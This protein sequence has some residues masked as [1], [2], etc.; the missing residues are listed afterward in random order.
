MKRQ[1]VKNAA[2]KTTKKKHSH[3][4]YSSK[5]NKSGGNKDANAS[6]SYGLRTSELSPMPKP[7]RLLDEFIIND[8]GR[9]AEA[10]VK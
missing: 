8:F 1:S 5:A 4:Y 2:T 10:K 3:Y 6:E 7:S 9:I